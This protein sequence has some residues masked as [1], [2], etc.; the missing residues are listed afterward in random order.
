VLQVRILVRPEERRDWECVETIV[1]DAFGQDAEARLVSRLRSVTGVFSLVATVDDT[2]VG[3]VLFSP[4]TARSGM[5]APIAYGLA[6]V[7]VAPTWQRRG[8]GAQLITVGLEELRS[9]GVGLV[10][11]LGHASYYPRFGFVPAAT[12][13][14]SCKWGGEDGSFQ[15][16][17]L[18]VGSARAYRGVVD[19]HPAFDETAW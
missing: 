12:L 13:G 7:A 1:G 16:V 9:V 11:V 6:P 8:I 2:V 19:Y 14:L 18:V 5:R 4:L 3:H 10:V 15:A 17:E